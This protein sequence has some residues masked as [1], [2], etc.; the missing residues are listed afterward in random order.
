MS[1]YKTYNISEFG[2]KERHHLLTGSISPRPIAWAS[3]VD[4]EGNI[5][6]SPFS[7]FNLFGT[8]PPIVVFSPNLRGRDGSVK[9]TLKNV[10]EVKEVVINIVTEELAEAMDITSKEVPEHINEF[11][12]AGLTMLDS[13]SIKPPR[14]KESPI[15]MECVVN[16]IVEL[17]KEGAAGN[18]VICE[19]IKLHIAEEILDEYGYVD[20]SKINFLARGGGNDYY[21]AGKENCFQMQKD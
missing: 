5:N 6:L 19:V 15:Q 1:K 8:N 12:L 13:E 11:E 18:L 14:V 2:I 10:K 21:V 3:T 4:L 20:S 17:G 16:E 9:D 7:Y